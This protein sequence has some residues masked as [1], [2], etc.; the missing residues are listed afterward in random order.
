MVDHEKVTYEPFRRAFYHPTP[1]IAEMSEEDA[2]N[3]RLAMD[4]I[5]IRGVDCP[6]P[7]A[8]WSQCGLPANWCAFLTSFSSPVANWRNLLQPGCH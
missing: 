5:K 6:K 3:L 2:D 4:G 7:V 8:K 1:E